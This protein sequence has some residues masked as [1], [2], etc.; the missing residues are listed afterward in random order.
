MAEFIQKNAG[1]LFVS[2]CELTAIITA[3]LY[4]RKDKVGAF[5]LIYL[6]ID[7]SI[8]IIDIYLLNSTKFSTAQVNFFVAR[9]NLF[10]SI[11]EL[12]A[13]YVFFYNT[14]RKKNVLKVL[15]YLIALFLLIVGIFYITEFSFIESRRSYVTNIISVFGFLLLLIPCISFFGQLLNSD[16][17]TN[18]FDRPSFWI[19]TGIFYFALMSIPFYLLE[20]YIASNKY[21]FKNSIDIP[22]FYL[23]LAINFIFLT[24]AFLC[25]KTLTI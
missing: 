4:A 20:R 6:I 2:L 16:F 14:L 17:S 1:Y 9:S 11:V 25:K 21:Q 3:L 13:Y 22:L 23:P 15:K 10:I 24:K 8:L 18:L 7:F 5:L 12:L 19:S